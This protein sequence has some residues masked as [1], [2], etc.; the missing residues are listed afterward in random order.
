MNY[1]EESKKLKESIQTYQAKIPELEKGLNKR[2]RAQAELEEEAL[3]SEILEER[4][5]QKRKEEAEKNREEI[6]RLR[7]EIEKC[8]NAIEILGDK[9]NHIQS[10]VNS[11]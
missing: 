10:G 11:S 9:K 3:K 5:W 6:Y 7:A 4:G 8:K 2:I 1:I